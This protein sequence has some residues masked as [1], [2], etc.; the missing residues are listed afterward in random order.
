MRSGAP[1]SAG[2]PAF[3]GL[4]AHEQRWRLL[5]ELTQSDRRVHE[6]VEAVGEA[7]NLVSYHLRKLREQRLVHERRSSADG[8]DVYYSLDLDRL[9]QLYLETARNL[10]PGL[11][12]PV[13]APPRRRPTRKRAFSRV[14]FLCTHNSARSQMAEGILRSLAGDRFEV[15][16]AGTQPSRV[17]PLAVETMTKRGIDISHQ[18][19]KHMDEV[20]SRGFDYVITVCDCASEVCPVFTGRPERIHWSIPDPSAVEGGEP[21]RLAAFERAAD[22]LLTRTRYF[23]ALVDS[24]GVTVRTLRSSKGKQGKR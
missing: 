3:L 13:E 5:E 8:R 20:A 17:H 23:V 2:S 19:S 12:E 6:L 10:H 22:D 14:L 15:E 24:R 4:L 11:A 18:R 21:V 9:R 16:S 7:P 1:H